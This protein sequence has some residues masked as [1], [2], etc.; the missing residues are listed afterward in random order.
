[1]E[2]YIQIRGQIHYAEI[3]YVTLRK[4]TRICSAN[5]FALKTL[6]RSS[7]I[8]FDFFYAKTKKTTE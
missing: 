8:C 5:C 6:N 4:F 7:F 2:I 3:V 1:M